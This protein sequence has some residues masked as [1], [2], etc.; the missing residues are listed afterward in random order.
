MASVEFEPLA[1]ENIE[2]D[3]GISHPMASNNKYENGSQ[4]FNLHA[5]FVDTGNSNPKVPS[6]KNDSNLLNVEIINL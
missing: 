2:R 4:H 5:N 1:L 6:I 3:V